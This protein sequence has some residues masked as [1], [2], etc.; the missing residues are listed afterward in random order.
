MIPF[1]AHRPETVTE[2]VWVEYVQL[3]TAATHGKV[4]PPGA[5]RLNE[6]Y[7]Q[8]PEILVA[9]Q[10]LDFGPRWY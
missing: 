9:G 4:T 5:A 2:T 3:M 10:G 7:D 1:A 6:I 8:A